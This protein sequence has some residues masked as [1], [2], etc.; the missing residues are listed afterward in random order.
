LLFIK[1]LARN[2]WYSDFKSKIPN[3][4]VKS[5]TEIDAKTYNIVIKSSNTQI[6]YAK[7]TK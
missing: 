3:I 5:F 1:K 2:I 7:T 6:I 4:S